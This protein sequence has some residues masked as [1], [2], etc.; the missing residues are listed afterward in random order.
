MSDLENREGGAP[1]QP[2]AYGRASDNA[3]VY[4]SG[5]NQYVT[6]FHITAE[7]RGQA[8]QEA[9]ER[10]DVVVQVLARA[11]GEWAARCKDLEEQ[12]RRANTEGRAEA[13]AEFAEKLKDAELRIMRAQSTM[14]QAEEERARAEVLLAQAQEELAR[15]RREAE[16]DA[17]LEVER[18]AVPLPEPRGPSRDQEDTEQFSELLER[19][20]AELGAVREELRQL[21]EEIDEGAG[22]VVEGEWARRPGAGVPTAAAMSAMETSGSRAA[23]RLLP[24][25]PRWM[26]VGGVGALYL[27]P[28]W[29][30]MIVVTAVRAAFASDAALW[31]LVFFTAAT[32]AAGAVTCWLTFRLAQATDFNLLHRAS[33]ETVVWRVVVSLF[34]GGLFLFI[35]AFFTPL[36]WPGPF[37]EWGR[38]L[39]SAAGL[40]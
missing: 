5:A 12:V 15:R 29:T 4:Q 25:S 23:S 1:G 22:Q 38:G 30:P 8:A 13:R 3:H 6:H 40:G 19:A 10:A 2:R 9:R 24:G 37:G 17:E 31:H 35:A 36:S 16:R 7:A 39:A 18:D 21:G 14:R 26:L 28:S 27:L 20:E 34:T 32:A 33:E 11:V